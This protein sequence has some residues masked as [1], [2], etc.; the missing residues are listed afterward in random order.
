MAKSQLGSAKPLVAIYGRCVRKKYS[1][2]NKKLIAYLVVPYTH[3]MKRGSVEPKKHTPVFIDFRHYIL[4]VH[5]LQC[6][7]VTS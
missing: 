1:F 7:S 6:N 5:I 4:Y 2:R 3:I